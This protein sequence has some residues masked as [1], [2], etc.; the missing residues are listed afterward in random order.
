MA[1]LFELTPTSLG[2][3]DRD[4]IKVGRASR[5]VA[6]H[7]SR[8]GRAVRKVRV[9]RT[10]RV[11]IEPN[12]SMS[13]TRLVILYCEGIPGIGA[14][15]IVKAGYRVDPAARIPEVNG[16]T[17][18]GAIVIYLPRIA[19]VAVTSNGKYAIAGHIATEAEREACEGLRLW[20]RR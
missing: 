3:R 10:D 12:L 7:K 8:I 9:H 17:M 16:E 5:K 2:V 19:S 20:T 1:L 6:E 14:Q 15:C 11:P 13:C 4:A 18:L